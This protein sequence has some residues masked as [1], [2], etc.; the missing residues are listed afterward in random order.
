MS[1]TPENIEFYLCKLTAL[2][3]PWPRLPRSNAA[4]ALL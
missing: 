1:D 4:W 2:Y 3:P